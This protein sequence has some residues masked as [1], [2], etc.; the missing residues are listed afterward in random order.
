MIPTDLPLPHSS[1]SHRMSQSEKDELAE[2]WYA[3]MIKEDVDGSQQDLHSNLSTLTPS[4]GDQQEQRDSR[5]HYHDDHKYPLYKGDPSRDRLLDQDFQHRDSPDGY[6]I[7]KITPHYGSSN[8]EDR[9]RTDFLDGI[10]KSLSELSNNSDTDTRPTESK[11]DLR[12]TKKGWSIVDSQRRLEENYQRTRMQRQKER[13]NKQNK[14]IASANSA[15]ASYN[16]RSD[17]EYDSRRRRNSPDIYDS[18]SLPAT[19]RNQVKDDSIQ[20]ARGARQTWYGDDDQRTGNEPGGEPRPPSKYEPHNDSAVDDNGFAKARSKSWSHRSGRSVRTDRSHQSAKT[21]PTHSQKRRPWNVDK[22]LV[23]TLSPESEY[24]S[25]NDKSKGTSQKLQLPP[26]TL[27][28]MVENMDGML[29]ENPGGPDKYATVGA[30]PSPQ[31]DGTNSTN[32][33][34]ITRDRSPSLAFS[35]SKDAGRILQHFMPRTCGPMNGENPLTGVADFF[36]A[37][38]ADRLHPRNENRSRSNG[39]RSRRRSD[40][41]SGERSG[42]RSKERRRTPQKSRRSPESYTELIDRNSS[43]S[44]DMNNDTTVKFPKTRTQ[45]SLEEEILLGAYKDSRALSK[46]IEVR[47]TEDQGMATREKPYRHHQQ[48]RPSGKKKNAS[49]QFRKQKAQKDEKR[50]DDFH[51]WES[52]EYHEPRASGIDDIRA[53]SENFSNHA[54]LPLGFATNF[55][56][57]S[58]SIMPGQDSQKIAMGKSGADVLQQLTRCNAPGQQ[59]SPTKVSMQQKSMKDEAASSPSALNMFKNIQLKLNG[60]AATDPSGFPAEERDENPKNETEQEQR[61]QEKLDAVRARSMRNAQTFLELESADQ[62]QLFQ[63]DQKRSSAKQRLENLM[64]SDNNSTAT[65]G[66]SNVSSSSKTRKSNDEEMA[67]DMTSYDNEISHYMYVAYSQFGQ[68]A[69][70]VLKL[71]GQPSIPTPDRRK[72]EILIRI[73]MSTISATDC[74]I[75]RGEWKRTKL[76]PYI[77]PGTALIGKVMGREKKRPRG[78]TSAC[79]EPGDTVLSLSPSGGN[80]RYTCLQKHELIKIPPKLNPERVICLAETYLT[81]FQVLHLGQRGG[82]RYRDN[83]FQGKSILV[84]DGFSPLGKAIIELSRLGGASI[85]YGLIGGNSGGSGSS[86]SS[87]DTSQQYKILEQWGAIPLPNDPQE[88]LTLIGRQIDI[89]VTSYD[90]NR[91]EGENA[92]TSDHWKVLKKEGQVYVVCSHP[93]MSDVEQRNLILESGPSKTNDSKAFRMPSCRLSAREKMADRA[94]YYNLFDSWQGD[95]LSRVMAR[96]DLEHLVKLL[97]VDLLH[98]DVAERFPLS[99]VGKA[100]RILEQNKIMGHFICVPWQRDNKKKQQKN[101]TGKFLI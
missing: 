26:I 34:T 65:P 91:E 22:S 54:N 43:N 83:C 95:R 85:C 89:L 52:A 90:P 25:V 56:S 60:Q 100:Q 31:N 84:M 86:S 75:R 16:Q 24:S 51:N 18:R 2:Q 13:A 70:N 44:S 42:E 37:P 19:R 29:Q 9:S 82:M 38:G 21:I 96:K 41:R 78:P 48:Q 46:E 40:E 66:I 28:S 17:G 68:E 59:D 23:D 97:E 69:H 57:L 53:N 15:D 99:K 8:E 63:G 12:E 73:N 79:I 101:T 32:R 80:A 94:V 45:K 33:K 7:K 27:P 3:M 6:R 61:I 81:A 20:Q 74:A 76:D 88:W 11:V 77:V 14:S 87:V 50:W 55:G 71:C 64:S 10:I 35:S 92:I 98:P 36:D 72:G 39:R 62:A 58:A 1:S 30:P 49:N 67:T 5:S 47:E 4:T 93:A